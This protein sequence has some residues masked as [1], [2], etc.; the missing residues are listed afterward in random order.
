MNGLAEQL[1][2]QREAGLYR[3]RRVVSSPQQTEMVVD[4]RTML[5]FC[6]NDYLGLASHPEVI[7]ALQQAA[8]VYGVGSGAAHLINGHST[9]H[10]ALEEELAEFTNRPR[11]LL[12]STG[13]MANLGVASALLGRHD[14]LFEDRL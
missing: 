13:Y 12:Y 1:R 4:G 9:A 14:W 7:E 3:R 5:T 8:N 11:A 6:S 10:H 2:R